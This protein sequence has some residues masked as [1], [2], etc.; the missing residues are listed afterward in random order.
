MVSN[1]PGLSSARTETNPSPMLNIF[2][3][4]QS[5]A[6]YDEQNETIVPS[7]EFLHTLLSQQFVNVYFVR[8][9]LKLNPE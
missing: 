8:Y 7:N 6:M 5:H 9:D 3:V 1:V 4:Q 2:N